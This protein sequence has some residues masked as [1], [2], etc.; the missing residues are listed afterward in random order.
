M[1][2]LPS[3]LTDRGWK[4]ITRAPDRHFAVSVSWGGTVVSATI[5][6]VI[7]NARHMTRYIEWR[8]EQE[9]CCRTTRPG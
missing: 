9:Q 4:L 1:T 6:E 5:E 8:N 7:R 2:D 3:D